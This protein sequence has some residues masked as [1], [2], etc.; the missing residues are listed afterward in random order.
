MKH[1]RNRY[2]HGSIRK[3]PRANGFAWEFRFYC[4]DESGERKLKT[5]TFDALKYPT[6]TSVRKAV[7]PQLGALNSDTLSGKISATMKTIIDRYYAEEFPSLRHSTQSTNRSLIDL[8]IRPKFGDVRPSDVSA[9]L[10]KNWLD[11]CEFGAAQKARARNILSRLL[12]LAMLWEYIPVQRNPMQLVKVKGATKRQK[13]LVVLTPDQFKTYVQ[14]LPEPYNLMVLVSGCFGFRVSETLALKWVD[15]DFGEETVQVRRVITHNRIQELPKTDASADPLPIH[16]KLMAVLKLWRKKQD[17]DESW[18]FPSPRTGG[19]YSDSTIL[20]DYL[21]PAAAKLGIKGIGWHTFRH[22]YRSWLSA[23]GV[24]DAHAKD[25][26][27][28]SD[29]K[30]TMNV[31]GKTVSKE[32]RDGNT[33]VVKQQL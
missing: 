28:H 15:F 4:S 6:E 30:T 3:V 26:M 10:V 25:L 24:K 7:E 14:S 33:R 13:K 2:Q 20:T 17:Q 18:V 22:S 9:I 5:Q 21:K 29:I 32:M 31:Y 23:S 12:D 27:R 1:S 16:P 19:P 11:K 8:H